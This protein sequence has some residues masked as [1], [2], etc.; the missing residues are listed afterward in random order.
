MINTVKM[1]QKI[2]EVLVIDLEATCSSDLSIVPECMEIIEIGAVWVSSMNHILDQFQSFVRPIENPQL[3][4]FCTE[5]TGIE[6]HQI[7]QANTW[8]EVAN[9][10]RQFVAQYESTE[11]IWASW[12]VW[13]RK[14]IEKESYRHRVPNPLIKLSHC[15]LKADFAKSRKIKQVGMVTAL[16]ISGMSIEGEHHRAISDA[17]NISRL[18][19]YVLNSSAKM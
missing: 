17:L 8:P 6:Q 15:N 3:T 16:K 4:S 14:Q 12:G 18:L 9:A 11:S 13:D 19:P 7:D 2:G 5:L 1:P 10:L